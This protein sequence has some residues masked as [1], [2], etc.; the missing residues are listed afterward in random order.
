MLCG[1]FTLVC[2]II[3]EATSI[4]ENFIEIGIKIPN[5]LSKDLNT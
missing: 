4:I 2:L 5:F 3:N 1:C